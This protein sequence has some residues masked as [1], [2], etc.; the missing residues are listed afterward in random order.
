MCWQARAG[1]GL[2]LPPWGVCLRSR[3]GT[4]QCEASAPG[5]WVLGPAAASFGP[6]LSSWPLF[7]AL[8]KYVA[9]LD[10]GAP[11]EGSLAF[12]GAAQSGRAVAANELVV[13]SVWDM[14]HQSWY[15]APGRRSPEPQT[16]LGRTSS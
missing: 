4:E 12:A 6:R 1:R 2:G 14:G 11:V 7:P 10:G 16:R 8:R 13:R 15:R 5:P 3:Q 9:D